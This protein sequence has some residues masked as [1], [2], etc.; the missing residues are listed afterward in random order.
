MKLNGIPHGFYFS[1]F[2]KS[3][4]K[5]FFIVSDYFSIIFF[6]R[7]STLRNISALR[8][9][10]K[11]KIENLKNRNHVKRIFKTGFIYKNII[12]PLVFFISELESDRV[13]EQELF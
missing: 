9:S 2:R 13:D 8:V 7:K 4:Y 6:G 12:P 5:S 10:K 1:E 11:S 3:D